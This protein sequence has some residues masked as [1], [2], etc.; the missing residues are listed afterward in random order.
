MPK[1]YTKFK[2]F[3]VEKGIQQ[4]EIAE[5]INITPSH[6][7]L[8]LNGKRNKDFTGEQIKRICTTH[9]ISADDYF[10]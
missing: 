3:L 7:N 1:G 5:L 8:I 10:F 4:K 2:A 6:L 9:N